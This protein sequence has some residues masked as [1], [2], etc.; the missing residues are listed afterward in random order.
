MAECWTAGVK[1]G[2][3]AATIVKVFSEAA[4]GQAMSLKVRLPAAYLRG[5]FEPSF[6]LAW[7]ARIWCQRRSWR[8]PPTRQ[9][10]SVRLPPA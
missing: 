1:A 3:D 5:D 2:I 8:A 6:L 7:R 10:R 9:C 4:L